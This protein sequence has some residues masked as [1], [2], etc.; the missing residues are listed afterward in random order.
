MKS[1]KIITVSMLFLITL[2]MIDD[3][4]SNFLNEIMIPSWLIKVLILLIIIFTSVFRGNKDLEG[5]Q[6]LI[7]S[8][9]STGY[10]CC[11]ILFFDIFNLKSSTDI[12]FTNPF[13]LFM[14]IFSLIDIFRQYKKIGIS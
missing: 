9:V 7:W 1:F 3:H 4:N 14:L 10:L 12:S 8:I 11:L 5:K 2:L 13:T 6:A